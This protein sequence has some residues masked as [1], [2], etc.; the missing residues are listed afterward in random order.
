[1]KDIH[2]YFLNPNLALLIQH[3]ITS[4]MKEKDK[5]QIFEF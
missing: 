3:I 2:L 5:K 4:K 1:M